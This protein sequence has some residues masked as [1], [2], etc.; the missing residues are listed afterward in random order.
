MS[1]ESSGKLVN[2]GDGAY[3]L[4]IAKVL[5][6]ALASVAIPGVLFVAGKSIEES[7]KSR[8]LAVKY[9]EISVGILTGPPT[10]QTKNLRDWAIAN[11]NKHAEIKLGL[12]S[13]RELETE[14]L[15]VVSTASTSSQNF[16]VPAEPRKIKYVIVADTEEASLSSIKNYMSSGNARAS[17]HY[18]I[19]VDG[20]VE[21]LV[22]EANIAWHAGRSEWRGDS[23][24]NA[25][26]IGIGLVHLSS[27]DGKNWMNLPKSHPAV[28]PDYPPAQIESLVELLSQIATR[29]GLSPDA[30]LTKQDIAPDRRR[31]DLFGTGL[32]MVRKRVK[33]VSRESS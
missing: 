10:P 26:S 17:Y 9:V 22:D 23:N 3:R 16:T 4:E 32:E 8:E 12:E 20:T 19:G 30:I 5:I 6:T 18:V 21:K 2:S 25:V 33:A 7:L 1:K 28:G 24:L 11:I 31:T 29:Y 27:P 13:I 15:P 14:A